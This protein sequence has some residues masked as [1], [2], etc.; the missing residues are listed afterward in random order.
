[1]GRAVRDRCQICKMADHVMM[2]CRPL[3]ARYQINSAEKTKRSVIPMARVSFHIYHARFRELTN[4]DKGSAWL[5]S[6]C[7]GRYA[8]LLLYAFQYSD[9]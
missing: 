1:M 8:S 2:T 9:N 3:V 7:H 6:M 4:S 5:C